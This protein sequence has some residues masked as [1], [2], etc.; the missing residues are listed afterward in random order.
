VAIELDGLSPLRRTSR[1]FA[2]KQRQAC[3]ARLFFQSFLS[4]SSRATGIFLN[5]ASRYNTSLSQIQHDFSYYG[6]NMASQINIRLPDKPCT[7][8]RRTF[9]FFPGALEPSSL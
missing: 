8:A 4:S 3:H 1:I 6:D 9:N 5:F 2:P 7:R